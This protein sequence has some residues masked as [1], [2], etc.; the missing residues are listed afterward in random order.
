M[1]GIN[2]PP[3]AAK[4]GKA[5]CLIDDKCPADNSL[6]ISSPTT[7]KN[8]V[9]KPSFTIWLRSISK[10][11]DDIDNENFVFK[12]WK[13]SLLQGPFA[14][15]KP[16]MDARTISI[17]EADSCL[18]KSDKGEIRFKLLFCEEFIFFLVPLFFKSMPNRLYSFKLPILK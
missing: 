5:A 10:L 17:P 8:I 1:A 14:T 3:M 6:L 7:K 9:I 11:N 18:K 4:N 2:I 12:I 13:Y 15:S 16:R